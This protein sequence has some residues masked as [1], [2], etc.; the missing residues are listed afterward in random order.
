MSSSVAVK[1]AYVK[2]HREQNNG[3]YTNRNRSQWPRGLRRASAA[4]RLLGLRAR[5]PPGPW[6]SAC[7][8]CCVLL[9]RVFSSWSRQGKLNIFSLIISRLVLA[10]VIYCVCLGKSHDM[11][12]VV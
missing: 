12:T 10:F 6:I 4:S 8:D 5:I 3:S 7:C 11:S 2:N 9:G 1:R